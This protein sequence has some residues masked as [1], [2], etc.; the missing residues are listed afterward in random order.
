MA[1][2]DTSVLID[3]A[4]GN[5]SAVAAASKLQRGGQELLISSV[6]VFELASGWPAGL[7]EKRKEFLRA[8]SSVPLNDE[9]AELG[10]T[11]FAQLRASGQE[12]DAADA[13]IAA[14]ASTLGEPVLTRN[15]KHFKRVKG[16]EVIT[17]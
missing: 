4:N 11:I 7:G 16:L 3:L 1:V 8:F 12:I 6:S 2:V 5:Q 14:T 9:S 10:G 15:S 13:M 17:Y